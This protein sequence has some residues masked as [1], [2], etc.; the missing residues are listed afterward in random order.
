MILIYLSLIII[1]DTCILKLGY[2]VQLVACLT[3]EFEVQDS[4]PSL[5]HTFVEID[6][7]IF[8]VVIKKT[9]LPHISRARNFLSDKLV[10][11][12]KCSQKFTRPYEKITCPASQQ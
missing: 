8:P 9:F 4:I 6:H 12:G 3:E 7:E 1:S 2:V 5:A 10:L 11:Q